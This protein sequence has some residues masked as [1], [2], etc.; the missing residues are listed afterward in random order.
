METI[1]WWDRFCS[2]RHPQLSHAPP[3][4]SGR[5]PTYD[6]ADC[7]PNRPRT[8]RLP[9]FSPFLHP[10][11][12][13]SSPAGRDAE[14]GR[15]ASP[16]GIGYDPVH[17]NRSSKAWRRWMTGHCRRPAPLRHEP[18]FWGHGH[19]KTEAISRHPCIAPHCAAASVLCSRFAARRPVEVRTAAPRAPATCAGP[20]QGWR[21]AGHPKPPIVF[22]DFLG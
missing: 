6:R 13:C 14:N 4:R 8:R 5:S 7:R 22:A 3:L 19:A 1:D 15:V 21:P 11:R 17:W 12:D 9:P 10:R 18:R 16:P 20:Q 2:G